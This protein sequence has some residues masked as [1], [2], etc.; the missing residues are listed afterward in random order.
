[1]ST[2]SN[3][4]AAALEAYKKNGLD[5]NFE[6]V[7][8]LDRWK[9]VGGVKQESGRVVAAP[10][11]LDTVSTGVNLATGSEPI[12]IQSTRP[13]ATA[14]YNWSRMGYGIIITGKDLDE[15]TGPMRVIDLAQKYLDNAYAQAQ[16]ELNAKIVANS[17]SAFSELTSFYG[18][19]TSGQATGIFEELA[20]GSQ[21]NV[22]GGV[23]KASWVDSWQHQRVDF[24]DDFSANAHLLRKLI[25]DCY[26]RTPSREWPHLVLA[27][28]SAFTNYEATLTANERYMSTGGT[29]D[30]GAP[31]LMVMGVPMVFEPIMPASSTADEEFSFYVL[32]LK[33]ITLNHTPGGWFKLGKWTDMLPGAIDG[34]GCNLIVDVAVAVEHM[35]SSGVGV[36][37]DTN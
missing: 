36:D 34:Q 17:G 14:T 13:F 9:K 6:R 30:S 18:A 11:M 26:H 2:T 23:D 5:G 7:P 27:S 8:L 24:A 3:T 33:N 35:P 16:R 4:I 19:S 29:R 12:V 31:E 32:N 22:V 25:R 1:M 28:D 15:T 21:T 20:F 37:G 10:L